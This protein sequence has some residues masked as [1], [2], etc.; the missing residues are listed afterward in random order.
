MLKSNYHKTR[1]SLEEKVSNRRISLL[2]L[3]GEYALRIVGVIITLL[4]LFFTWNYAVSKTE[5]SYQRKV[6]NQHYAASV[7]CGSYSKREETFRKIIMIASRDDG[8][9]SAY[10]QSLSEATSSYHHAKVDVILADNYKKNM[11]DGHDALLLFA[12]DRF[13]EKEKIR[14]VIK[15][16]LEQKIKL[17]WIGIGVSEYA[18]LLGIGDEVITELEIGKADYQLT[19][20]NIAIGLSG[21]L[22]DRAFD[23]FDTTTAGQYDTRGIINYNSNNK[24]IFSIQNQDALVI[25]LVPFSNLEYS[26]LLSATLDSL[27]SILG[28]HRHNPRI[29]FRLEDINGRDYAD[30]NGE[31]FRI[32]VDYL[33]SENV[34]IHL[35]V[36]PQS[37]NADGVAIADIGSAKVVLNTIENNPDQV[38]IIQHGYLHYR[39]DLR[40]ANMAT[41]E[42]FEFFFDDDLNHGEKW[43]HSFANERLSKGINLLAGYGMTPKL[44]EAPHYEISEGAQE[45]ADKLFEV[46]HHPPLHHG[47]LRSDLLLPW[48][49]QRGQTRYAPSA[50]GYVDALNPNSVRDILYVLDTLKTII[51]DPVVVIHYHPFMRIKEGREQDLENLI[52]GAK[53]LGYRFVSTCQEL[54]GM[55]LTPEPK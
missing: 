36:I 52:V 7:E 37:V 44:F 3:L 41:G 38:E 35:S 51:P 53:E 5:L 14:E 45:A 33:L 32:T 1:N 30:E 43:S 47:G 25:P 27:S 22:I 55:F 50:V 2:I 29:L 13:S 26:F 16:A 34:F 15:A 11:L 17:I 19:Y 54:D 42:A 39:H 10:V 31:A 8:I 6:E 28:E 46:M 48:F 23:L 49:T 40:N 9:H 12:N 24:G 20:N 21:V 4:A 18:D